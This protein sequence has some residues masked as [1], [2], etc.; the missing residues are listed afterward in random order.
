MVLIKKDD[1]NIEF[2]YAEQV[3]FSVSASKA[4]KNEDQA[5]EDNE[6]PYTSSES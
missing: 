4:D 6:E 2:R 3:Q 1:I 5:E